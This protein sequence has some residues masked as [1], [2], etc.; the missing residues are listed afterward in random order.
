MSQFL[1]TRLCEFWRA[2]PSAIQADLDELS[3]R[4]KGSGKT[5]TD[6]VDCLPEGPRAAACQFRWAATCSRAK[7]VELTKHPARKRLIECRYY[8]AGLVEG[9]YSAFIHATTVPFVQFC[10]EARERAQALRQRYEFLADNDLESSWGNPMA[11]AQADFAAG[12]YTAAHA[13]AAFLYQGLPLPLVDQLAGQMPDGGRISMAVPAGR[14]ER[15]P[16]Y[17][18]RLVSEVVDNDPE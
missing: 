9:Y 13:V 18:G 8:L 5:L 15:E 11:V 16:L 2:V 3:R 7:L 17:V 6:L 10:G 1:D 4:H 12:E 14:D